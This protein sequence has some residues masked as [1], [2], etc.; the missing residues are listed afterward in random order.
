MYIYD[1]RK[2]EFYCKFKNSYEEN[3][4]ILKFL[5]SVILF[6]FIEIPKIT[7]KKGSQ[8]SKVSIW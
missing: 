4:F 8:K 5:K 6:E 2:I 1:N 3:K 7:Q